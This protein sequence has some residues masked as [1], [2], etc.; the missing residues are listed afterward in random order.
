MLCPAPAESGT[1]DA[2]FWTKGNHPSFGLTHGEDPEPP[3]LAILAGYYK[4]G[5]AARYS[6]LFEA[7]KQHGKQAMSPLGKL[8]KEKPDG[9]VKHRII[10]DLRKG[11]G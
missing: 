6:S 1:L 11:G 10:Q 7:E 5:Y 3:G 8:S 9:S 4:K 2:N